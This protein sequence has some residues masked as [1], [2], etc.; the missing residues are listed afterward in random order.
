MS[1]EAA[2]LQFSGRDPREPSKLKQQRD[3]PNREEEPLHKEKDKHEFAWMKPHAE[4]EDLWHAGFG[5]VDF[6]HKYLRI[7]HI[8]D[9][10]RIF[11]N[12]DGLVYPSG[13]CARAT[14]IRGRM[15]AHG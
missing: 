8:Q 14:S 13:A 4:L 3:A 11:Q 5:A 7:G 2:R 9:R 15:M 10:T 1:I 6:C 12:L